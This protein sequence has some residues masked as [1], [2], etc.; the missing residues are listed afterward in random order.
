MRGH[1]ELDNRLHYILDVIYRDDACRARK[2]YSPRTLA[3][4][5]KIALSIARSDKE[6]KIGVRSR[7]QQLA[8]SEDYPESLLFRSDFASVPQAT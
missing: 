8:L 2:D 7:V 4:I 6:S 1:W 3:M 5:R